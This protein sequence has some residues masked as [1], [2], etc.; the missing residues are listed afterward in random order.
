MGFQQAMEKPIPIVKTLTITM[1]QVYSGASIPVEIERWILENGN[2]VFE[3][4]TIYV[5]IPQ[6]IDEKEMLIMRDRGNIIS[7]QLKGDIK[8]VITIQNDTAFN[9]VGL[10]L[11]LTKKISLKEALCGFSFEFKHISGKSYTMNN[12]KGIIVTPDYKKIYQGMGLKR[13]EHTG[14][15]IIHFQV[16]FPEKLTN[17]QID[18]LIDIL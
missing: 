5:D 2:K 16:E 7:D 8:L 15:M 6:G 18:K 11:V 9:R 10:D 3:K 14:N 1:E 17:E 12:N 13:G 4:E